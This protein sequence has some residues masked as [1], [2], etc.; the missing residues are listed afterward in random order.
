MKP[1]VFYVSG[2]PAPWVSPKRGRYGGSIPTPGSEHMDAWKKRVTLAAKA[3][4]RKRDGKFT[5]PVSLLVAFTMDG[6]EPGATIFVEPCEVLDGAV[7]HDRKPDLTNLIKATE[8][9]LSGVVFEDDRAVA[10]LLAY[11]FGGGPC[12]K[13][14]HRKSSTAS[15]A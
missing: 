6:D 15:R 1:L 8:D 7:M 2:V 5:G 4:M 9:A 14:R 11:K 10:A 3:A 12:R 13:T